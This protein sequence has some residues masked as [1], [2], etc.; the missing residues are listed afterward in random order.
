MGYDICGRKSEIP[1][2]TTLAMIKLNQVGN[3]VGKIPK[4][5]L[6]ILF[7]YIYA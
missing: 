7:V 6:S 4:N 1:F 3:G 2:H 5:L